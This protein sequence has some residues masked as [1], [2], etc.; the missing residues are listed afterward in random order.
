VVPAFSMHKK[1]PIS[2]RVHTA[3]SQQNLMSAFASALGGCTHD[4]AGGVKPWVH[5]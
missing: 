1:S 4:G 5:K 2:W 3:S